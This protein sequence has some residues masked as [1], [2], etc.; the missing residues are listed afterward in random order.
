M[1]NEQID[2]LFLGGIFNSLGNHWQRQ[3]A[4]LYLNGLW[5]EHRDWDR[6]VRDEWVAE[7]QALVVNHPRPIVVVAHSLGNLLWLEWANQYP[8][9]ENIRGAFMVAIPDPEL[10]TIPAQ[11]QGF[12]R[13][14]DQP[15][16]H[17]VIVVTSENDPYGSAAYARQSAEQWGAQCISVGDAGHINGESNLGQWPQGRTL[18]EGF[19]RERIE[20]R[21]PSTAKR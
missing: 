10:P 11:I 8:Q 16:Q 15:I 18:L 7:L 2:L 3:W 20:P 6:P 19:I 12:K 13:A 1:L 14:V 4:E 9:A 5:L 21:L 17:P